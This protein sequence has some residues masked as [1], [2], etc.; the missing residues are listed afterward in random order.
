MKKIKKIVVLAGMG[1]GMCFFAGCGNEGT[2]G[3]L[4]TGEEIAVEQKE[5]AEDAVEQSNSAVEEFQQQADSI[6]EE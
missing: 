3:R 5:R 2:E 1:F 6:G 4:K